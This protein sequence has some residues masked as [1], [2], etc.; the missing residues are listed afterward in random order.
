MVNVLLDGGSDGERSRERLT[1]DLSQH[2][3]ILFDLEVL[4][5]LRRYLARGISSQQQAADAAYVALAEVLGRP[6][7]HRRRPPRG[8]SRAALCDRTV[9]VSVLPLCS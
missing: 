8:G 4:A 1:S 9:G 2:A 3:P 6:A 7:A 5:A